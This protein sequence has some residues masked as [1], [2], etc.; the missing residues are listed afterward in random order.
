MKISL[1]EKTVGTVGTDGGGP[2]EDAG[3]DEAGY[4]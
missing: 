3:D 1:V 4:V 2:D